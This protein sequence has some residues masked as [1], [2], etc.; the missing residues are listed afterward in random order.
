MQEIIES[1]SSLHPASQ[2]VQ[3]T[4][5]RRQLVDVDSAPVLHE[6]S[7]SPVTILTPLREPGNQLQYRALVPLEKLVQHQLLSEERLDR[8]DALRFK[9][10]PQVIDGEFDHFLE[11]SVSI[12]GKMTPG[13]FESL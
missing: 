5:D 6:D 7:S 9:L 3:G 11:R 10:F 12:A 2:M 13:V 8:V 4:R 1:K